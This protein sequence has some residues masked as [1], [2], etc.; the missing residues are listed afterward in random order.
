MQQLAQDLKGIMLHEKKPISKGY[1]L[2]DSTYTT[3]LRYQNNSDREI[4][5]IARGGGLESR[6][7]MSG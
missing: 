5:V 7:S 3:F 2:Y 4:S 1:I 6:E